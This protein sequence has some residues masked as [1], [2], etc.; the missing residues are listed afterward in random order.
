MKRIVSIFLMLVGIV[1]CIFAQDSYYYFQGK[2]CSL[3]V[4]PHK[5]VIIAENGIAIPTIS[6]IKSA[7]IVYDNLT[8]IRICELRSGVSASSLIRQISPSSKG[9]VKMLPTYHSHTGGELS[10]N[11]YIYVE[12][13]NQSDL[14]VLQSLATQFDCK[15]VDHDEFMPLWYTLRLDVDTDLD[16]VGVANSIYETGKVKS[17]QP[18]FQSINREISYDPYVDQQWGL[19]NS[20]FEGFDIS[21]SEAWDYA[22]GRGIKIAIIDGGVDLAHKDL[23]ANIY[24]DSYDAA[25]NSSPSKIYDDGHATHCAGIAA[26]VRNNNY[27]IAGIAP[28]AKIISTSVQIGAKCEEC[29]FSRAINWAWQNGAD[30][31]SCSWGAEVYS[32]K[33]AQAFENALA[34]GRNGRGCVVMTSAGNISSSHPTSDI[35]FPGNYSEKIITVGAIDADG[36]IPEFSCYGDNMFIAAPGVGIVSTYPNNTVH[37][38][39]GTSMAC[40]HVAGVTALI[41]ERNPLLKESAVRQVLG[42]S[43]KKIGFIPYS[44]KKPHG[45]WNEKYGYG[46]LDAYTSIL[47]TPR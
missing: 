23:A 24:H 17:C 36:T 2:R 14:S 46:V 20:D 12:L 35:T 43:A 34:S 37:T 4:N 1:M 42:K 22:T 16:P 32:E 27:M 21:I 13:I 41:L 39:N 11:G 40:P 15:I 5:V 38:A 44:E 31:L 7:K 33:I 3:S 47:N 25:S 45:T 28:D 10:P 26:A 6:G 9:K 8:Q 18:S 19:Y 29:Q 30:I